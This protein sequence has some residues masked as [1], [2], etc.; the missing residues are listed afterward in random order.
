MLVS[1][2][3]A[4][5]SKERERNIWLVRKGRGAKRSEA[6]LHDPSFRIA[7]FG[8]KRHTKEEPLKVFL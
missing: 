7:R 4:A 8:F 5:L 6:H 2:L 1:W 3:V